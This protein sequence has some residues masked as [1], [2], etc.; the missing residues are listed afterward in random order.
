MGATGSDQVQ[1]LVHIYFAPYRKYINRLRS[2]DVRNENQRTIITG[3][4][5]DI[6]APGLF[7]AAK[8]IKIC[9][10]FCKNL[11]KLDQHLYKLC[12]PCNA[13]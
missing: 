11:C 6:K 1:V 2:P 13:T 12:Q 8:Q 4:Q 9:V 3:A 7:V 10:N 5:S